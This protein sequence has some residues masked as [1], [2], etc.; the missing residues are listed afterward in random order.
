MC[1][2]ES[3]GDTAA[4]VSLVR[5]STTAWRAALSPSSTPLHSTGGQRRMVV[6]GGWRGL[7]AS[8]DGLD[9]G[10]VETW[11]RRRGRCGEGGG[12]RGCGGGRGGHGGGHGGRRQARW[13]GVEGRSSAATFNLAGSVLRVGQWHAGFGIARTREHHRGRQHEAG[14]QTRGIAA[15]SACAC[16]CAWQHGASSF[17]AFVDL[18]AF[19][20][21]T[22]D[23][24]VH[25]LSGTEAGQQQLATQGAGTGSASCL[26][27]QHTRRPQTRG[28]AVH[29]S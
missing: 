12:W 21:F 8:R 13:R 23:S 2:C 16:A 28:C 7:V 19:S 4:S 5:S 18:L 1:V 26:Q 24:E 27:E 22:H 11:R 10:L 9:G 3:E 6:C 25:G 20:S 17:G 14:G 29:N 15:A